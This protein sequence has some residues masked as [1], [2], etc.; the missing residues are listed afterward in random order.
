MIHHSNPQCDTC[1]QR[2]T[3]NDLDE[4]L[5]CILAA[6]SEEIFDLKAENERLR[7]AVERLDNRD[8]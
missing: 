6:T 1:G 7:T 2:H 8:A 3:P 4:C 5:D